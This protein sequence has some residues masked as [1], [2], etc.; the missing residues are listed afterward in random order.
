MR[1]TFNKVHDHFKLNGIPFSFEALKE[2]A[3]SFII[4]GEFFEKETGSFLSD[5]LDDN[6]FIQAKTSGSTGKPKTIRLSKEAMVNSA[7]AT[8]AF[9]KLKPGNT[10]LLCLPATYIAGKMMLVRALILGLELDTVKPSTTPVFSTTKHYD[11]CAMIPAQ[12]EHTLDKLETI[13]TLI[14][15]GAPINQTLK[16]KI[17]PLKTKVYETYGMTETITHIAVKQLNNINK[18]EKCHAEIVEA[19]LFQTLPN[20]TISQNKKGCLVI[21]AP[22]LI[23]TQITTN[24]LVKLH[25][26]TSFQWL[27][28]VD[29]VINS[30]GVKLFPEQIEAK[31]QSKIES[32]FFIAS[33]EDKTF[34]EQVVL[35]IEA[36]H[37][38]LNSSVFEDLNTLETPKK[39]YTISSFIETTSGKINRKKTLA[40]FKK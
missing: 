22:Q 18:D 25:S 1:P 11:F 19:F 21:D 30:G 28:R 10:A 20:I 16:E 38:T 13:E 27:G 15:G 32:R 34:G 14:V 40:L 9:F 35:V 8:G 3:N 4:K 33:I 12:V 31:L 2:M 5:W 6:D 37:N 29:N 39:V 7:I 36:E 24:D 26:K 23:A 17:T